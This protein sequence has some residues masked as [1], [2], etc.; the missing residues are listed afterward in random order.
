M[1]PQRCCAL[2]LTLLRARQEELQVL[3]LR[4]LRALVDPS[5]DYC[6]EDLLNI[7]QLTPKIVNA[8]LLKLI[9]QHA[10]LCLDTLALLALKDEF[11]DYMS[12][13]SSLL[14]FLAHCCQQPSDNSKEALGDAAR[15]TAAK[16]LAN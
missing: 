2:L 3:G 10:Q 14:V 8:V 6:C 1:T 16:C 12:A 7:G 15:R 13:Q 11:R 5:S 4:V 9:Q